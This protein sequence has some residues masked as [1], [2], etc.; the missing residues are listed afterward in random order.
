M[1]T[2]HTRRRLPAPPRRLDRPRPWAAPGDAASDPQRAAPAGVAS[3]ALGF[4]S[5]GPVWLD[6]YKSKRPPSP[7]ELINAYKAV[8]YACVRLNAQGVSRAPLRLYATTRA[9]QRGPRRSH[10]PVPIARERRLRD[11]VSRAIGPNDDVQ[12]ITEHPLLDALDRPNPFFDLPTLL[13]YLVACLDVAGSAFVAPFRAGD[14]ASWTA[15]ELWPLQPQ[16]VFPIRTG[17]NVLTGWRY[18]V[19][20]F[21][22][23]GLVRFRW[24]SLRDPYLSGYSPL[25][26]CFEQAGLIDY[27]TASVEGIL[28]GGAMPSGIVSAAD[29]A[30]PLGD[31]QAERLEHDLNNRFGGRGRGKL[32]VQRF[33]IKVQPLSFS[34]TDLGGLEL[35]KEQRLLA[36]NCFDVPISLLQSEDSNRATAQESSYQ[37]AYYAI[38]PR[39][40][41][42]E[43]AL[44]Q[45]LCRPVDPR[46]FFAFDDPV[47]RDVQR[48]AMIVDMAVKNGTKTINEARAEE[49]LEPVDWGD[50]PWLA[51]TLTQPTAAAEAREAEAETEAKA[52]AIEAQA[53]P[54]AGE[55]GEGQPATDNVQALA[56]NGA[57]VASMLDIAAK[58]AIAEIPH[59]SAK[60]MLKAAFPAVSDATIDAIIDTIE[61]KEPPPPAPP[62]IGP[63][64]MGEGT[65]KP[66]KPDDDDEREPPDARRSFY[67]RLN[68]ALD[69]IVGPEPAR[70][71]EGDGTRRNADERG[72]DTDADTVTDAVL[73]H[74]S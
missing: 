45:Q 74:D 43:A 30:M 11:V 3:G 29:P 50:E 52:K 24:P 54:A 68:Q 7:F 47:Q 16:Y 22:P 4:S 1:P 58:V 32:W 73:N 63:P 49:G 69:L 46:L 56:L 35:S 2:P 26:A 38:A 40:R 72:E 60:A 5:G 48:D 33:P 17:N 62:M 55:T 6:A 57:Q 19:D 23:D 67:A 28:Q 64:G 8:A 66:P 25:H 53:K 21:A 37:H 42:I 9:G 10:R 12:E 51:N 61:A 65:G 31:E 36:A 27:Y 34:P 70:V 14:D 44:T 18:F 15:T 71:K 39:C 59:A 13:S 20:D 41:L